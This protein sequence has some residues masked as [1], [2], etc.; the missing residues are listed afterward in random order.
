LSDDLQIQALRASGGCDELKSPPLA[1]RAC[2]AAALLI[3]AGF[4][5]ITNSCGKSKSPA[6]PSGTPTTRVIALSPAI[7][8]IMR[9]IGQ[10]DLIIGRHASD[11]WTDQS[12]PACGDQVSG[13][14]YERL[15]QAR[16]THVFLQMA[17]APPKLVEMGRDRGFIVRNYAILTLDEIRLTTRELWNWSG[18]AGAPEANTTERV[19]IE[20]R[21][22]AAWSAHPSINSTKVGRV[23]LLA[24]VDPAGALGP[25]SWHHDI[26]TRVGASPAT[27][28]G[29][30]FVT[31]DAEDV[32]RSAP[33]AIILFSPRPP[34]TPARTPPPTP[35]ELTAMLGTLG[36]LN[37]PAVQNARI[38]LIDDPM[39]HLP[40]TAMIRVAE[41]MA[42]ILEKWSE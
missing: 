6:P 35:A 20:G 26:L 13:I 3:L 4:A 33:D 39:C 7:A 21:M 27:R 12:I 32:L 9:D 15:I 24:Q 16:P 2:I 40:S 31:M 36:K 30:A 29:N 38:A 22:D 5:S 1:R 19:P 25:G 17:E 10:G 37:L 28:E 34:G 8:S 42:R 23:L 11:E 18:R 41:E 14:D